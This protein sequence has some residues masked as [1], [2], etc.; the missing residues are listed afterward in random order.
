MILSK[1][2]R[3]EIGK[4]IRVSEAAKLAGVT[5]SVVWRLIYRGELDALREPVLVNPKDV[6][7]L[8]VKRSRGRPRKKNV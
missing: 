7:K 2:A 8:V 3:A 5:S 1:K 6:L 4:L